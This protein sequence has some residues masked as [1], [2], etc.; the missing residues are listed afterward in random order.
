LIKAGDD[1]AEIERIKAKY[2]IPVYFKKLD[3]TKTYCKFLLDSSNMIRGM[4]SELDSNYKQTGKVVIKDFSNNI[5]VLDNDQLLEFT[6]AKISGMA[7]NQ[8]YCSYIDGYATKYKSFSNFINDN[9]QELTTD[10]KKDISV[11]GAGA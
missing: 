10:S 2:E 11:G 6:Q 8:F 9:F 1:S 3:Y 5:F 4:E 7:D